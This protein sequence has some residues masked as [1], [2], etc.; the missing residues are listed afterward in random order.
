MEK[1]KPKKTFSRTNVTRM[2]D[3]WEQGKSVSEIGRIIGHTPGSV[4]THLRNHGG[5]RP[6]SHKRAELQ[7]SK[8][9]REEISRELLNKSS[10]REIARILNR[11]P[12]TISREVNRNGGRRYYRAH[13]A[14]KRFA[15]NRSRPKKYKLDENPELAKIISIKLSEYWSPEQISG[16]LK[17]T[18]P[19]SPSLQISH[20]T[21]Y[22]TIFISGRTALDRRLYHFLRT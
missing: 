20:E 5:I 8:Y 15:V 17:R 22:R 3:Y 12:S 4:H 14:E 16:W 11:A 9:E 7:L 13:L 10:F 6:W 21:I 1:T 2:W 18:Y 19:N